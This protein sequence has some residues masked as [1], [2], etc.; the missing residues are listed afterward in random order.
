[1][2]SFRSLGIDTDGDGIG[3]VADEDDDGDGLLDSEELI[4]LTDALNPD[5]DGDLIL[6]GKM[7]SSTPASRWTLTKMALETMLIWI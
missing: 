7:R 4:A 2:P 6:D 5:S 1:M 3:N